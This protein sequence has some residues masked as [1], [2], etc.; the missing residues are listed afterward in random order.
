MYALNFCTLVLHSPSFFLSREVSNLRHLLPKIDVSNQ[1]LAS[2]GDTLSCRGSLSLSFLWAPGI[3]FL[4]VADRFLLFLV[5]VGVVFF[6]FDVFFVC[7]V[8]F[9]WDG[10]NTNPYFSEVYSKKTIAHVARKRTH[11]GGGSDNLFL[12][13]HVVGNRQNI[14]I[15]EYESFVGRIK[16][17]Y[18]FQKKKKF[19]SKLRKG[20]PL[21]HSAG[22]EEKEKKKRRRKKRKEGE[23]RGWLDNLFLSCGVR[24]RKQIYL[25]VRKS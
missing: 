1:L 18:W 6:F 3:A 8:F 10:L 7:P 22:R 23:G 4:P 12:S 11:V 13:C 2:A 15:R 16:F 21:F 20:C 24:W 14:C 25:I 5:C 19:D 17:H 9:F